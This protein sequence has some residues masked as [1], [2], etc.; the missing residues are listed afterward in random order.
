MAPFDAHV[1]SHTGP[2]PCL[3]PPHLPL[4]QTAEPS[5]PP[6]LSGCPSPSFKPPLLS[7]PPASAGAVVTCPQ[8]A[9]HDRLH[10]ILFTASS[11]P[12]N[13][14]LQGPPQHPQTSSHVAQ[15]K[16]SALCHRILEASFPS[17]LKALP[18]PSLGRQVCRWNRHRPQ[19]LPGSG[20]PAV[21]RCQHKQWR[22]G[23]TFARCFYE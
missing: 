16:R 21:G 11:T 23:E 7:P 2:V 15:S 19:T 8:Q 6:L 3:P 12:P 14:V 18:G 22:Q 13:P 20:P 17:F 4:G 1:P 9:G 5:S 10:F